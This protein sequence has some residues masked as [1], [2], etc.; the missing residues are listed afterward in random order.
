MTQNTGLFKELD[1]TYFSKVT[2]GNGECADGVWTHKHNILK[3]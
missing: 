2:T 1:H 3:W